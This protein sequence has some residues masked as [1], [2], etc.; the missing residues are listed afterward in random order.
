V[1]IPAGAETGARVRVPGEGQFGIGGGP[2][3]DLFL[4]V[5]VKPDAL[6]ERKG[7]DLTVEV[8][9][10]LTTAVLGGEVPV[11]TPD[12]K[13]LILT[14]PPETQNGQIFRLTGKGMPRLKGDGAGN[15]YA[16]VAVQLPKR[17]TPREKQLFEELAR[18][19]TAD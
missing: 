9:V 11:P 18:M 2:R 10:P 3:G 13:R 15:L 17:L 19:R 6:Y 1:R 12:G 16:R 5:T 7:E 14:I 8:S 4:V